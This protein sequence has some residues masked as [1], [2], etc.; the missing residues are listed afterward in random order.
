MAAA[1][2][3]VTVTLL[4]LAVS[5]LVLH[6]LLIP[7]NRPDALTWAA[8]TNFPLELPV[9][10]LALLALSRGRLGTVF[11][12]SLVALLVLLAVLKV[13]DIAMSLALARPFNAV[14][15]MPLVSAGL[16]L[17]ASSIGPFP[18]ALGVLGA[19]TVVVLS[20][21]AAF[22]ATG[23]WVRTTPG[24][25]GGAG[26]AAAAFGF[27]MIVVAKA[28][29]QP[30]L[31]SALP[32]SATTTRIATEQIN[33]ATQTFTALRDFARRAAE[34]PYADRGDLLDAIDRDVF[35]I[36]VESY[37]RASFDTGLCTPTHLATLREAE[38]KL[39]D[40]GFA[41][42]SGW[43][44]APTRGGQSWLSHATFANGIRVE[45]QTSYGAILASPRETL[46]HI[47]AR[48]GF[49][50]AAVMPQITL[51]WPEASRMGFDT[52]LAAKDL[53]YEGE[54]FNWVTMPDQYTYSALDRKLRDGSQDRPLF[55]QVATGSSH[56]PWVP[57]P[58]MVPWADIGDGHIFDE[59][60]TSGATPQEVWSDHDR[61]REQYRQAIDY[62]L[63]AVFDYIARQSGAPPLV[64]IVGDHQAAGFVAQ[65]DRNDVPIHV[66]GPPNLLD[67]ISHWDWSRGLRPGADVEVR[68]MGAM[69]NLILDA[70]TSL[71]PRD[72][73]VAD[74][75]S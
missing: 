56:A 16:R 43:L 3:R 32:G 54:P 66:V 10:L 2:A 9:I 65:D 11:R 15:D 57:V 17:L 44:D 4:R 28:S 72:A 36:F 18:A 20:A 26:A 73:T 68:P 63:T 21:A 22:W 48:S 61:V 25:M 64:F 69:R 42:R 13:A 59:M 62:A 40:L 49:R 29:G 23:V 55:V 37:G 12:I 51:D 39:S 52:V 1:E 74:C 47:A 7:P 27:A 14:A 45:N 24:R 50:T 70:F 6:V 60:A 33:L 30:G 46:F 58:R 71:C 41:M 34:D 35:V 5:A 53:G 31:P 8:L 67:R 38:A 75:N 19:G